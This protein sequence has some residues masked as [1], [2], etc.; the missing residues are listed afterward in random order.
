MS[1]ARQAPMIHR[2]MAT[3]DDG[4]GPLRPPRSLFHAIGA[5][6]PRLALLALVLCGTGLFLGLQ[7]APPARPGSL[8]R[9]I[10]IHAPAAW[11]SDGL[12]ALV[13]AFA[14]AGLVTRWRLPSM[15]AQALAPT[16]AMFALVALWTGT[17]WGRQSTRAWWDAHLV[18]EAALLFL[19]VAIVLLRAAMEDGALAD[20]VTGI[21]A[22]AGFACLPVLMGFPTHWSPLHRFL[23]EYRPGPGGMLAPGMALAA[24]TAGFAMYAMAVALL[25]LRCIV[26]ERDRSSEWV[27]TR[28]RGRQ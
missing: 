7:G 11:V 27:E 19:F 15:V 13:A 10:F 6:A 25:R 17:L 20:R 9:I 14:G 22:L 3:P 12:F 23:R 16:G 8:Y 4:A 5:W 18:L 21:V 2:E 24:I 1:H 28:H 26:L